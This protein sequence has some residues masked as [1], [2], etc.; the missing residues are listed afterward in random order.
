M[1]NQLTKSARDDIQSL[2]A[3]CR[4]IKAVARQ[5]GFSRNTVRSVLRVA[6]ITVPEPLKIDPGE[7]K[8][9]EHGF[10]LDAL[11]FSLL[12]RMFEAGRSPGGEPLEFEKHIKKLAIG[13]A[14]EMGIRGTLDQVRLE[15]AL[16]QYIVYRRFYFRS[17]EASDKSYIGP[18]SKSYEKTAKAVNHWVQN[19]RLALEQCWDLF[20]EL[21]VKYGKRF[22]ESRGTNIFVTQQQLHVSGD[23][24][25]GQSALHHVR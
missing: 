15:T 10:A 5:L 9:A 22:P 7:K 1:P 2:F 19:S 4:S 14:K 25:T 21:E 24:V 3:S 6:G 8:D 23:A 17:L 20:R 16:A 12:E 11:D 18:F 13:I